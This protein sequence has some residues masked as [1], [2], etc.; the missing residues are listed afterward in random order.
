MNRKTGNNRPDRSRSARAI[1]TLLALLTALAGTLAPAQEG[2]GGPRPDAT[3]T[4]PAAASEPGPTEGTADGEPAEGAEQEAP[5]LFEQWRETLLYGIDSEVESILPQMLQAGEDGLDEELVA[6]FGATRSDDLRA[7]ILD[8][9]AE[10]ESPILGDAV[11]TL[12]LTDETLDD[13]LLRGASSYLSRVVGDPSPE[14]LERYAEIAEDA[15]LLAA[16]VA[17]GAIGRNGSPEAV[18]L[19]LELYE[20]LRSSDLRAAIIRAL[21][22]AGDPAALELLT[23]IASDEFEESSLRQY[24]AE[25]LGK[26]GEPESLALLT[27]LLGVDDSLLR[28]YATYALGFY[29]TDEAAALLEQAL[30]DSFWRVR[31]AAL[32]ALGEQ[33]RASALPAIA[34]KARRDPERP[35]REE[36]IKALGRIAVDEGREVLRELAMSERTG[37]TERMLALE[38]LAASPDR[39]A[40]EV[41]DRVITDEWARDGSRLLDT[42]G[43]LISEEPSNAYAPLYDRLLEHPN[44]II[45]IYAMRGVGGAGIRTRVDELKRVARENPPGLLRR[46]A[47]ASLQKMGIDYDPQSVPE[48]ENA[49]ASPDAP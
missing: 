42:I 37:E 27:S 6:R 35:V 47:L 12:I 2:P 40:I 3:G 34:Y 26:I 9:F 15:N 8:H 10:R 49:P 16:S 25:S 29:D 43:R 19:L 31:V 38:H 7:A 21:G 46:T 20:Q 32:E 11:R 5:S 44:F 13:D 18:D 48:S 14:L 28:A 4:D 45:R 24:A 36:A 30:L 1:A 23:R 17:I 33:G 22:E 39:D 41:F